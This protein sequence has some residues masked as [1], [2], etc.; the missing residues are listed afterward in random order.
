MIACKKDPL[1]KPQISIESINTLIP[2]GGGLQAK[3]KFT[4][5]N[6]KLATGIFIAIRNRLNQIPLP[7]GTAS[8][9]TLT[10]PIP[11]FPDKNKGEF[12]FTLDYSYLHQSD[13]ENDTIQFKFAVVDAGGNKSDTVTSDKVVVLF[14]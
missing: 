4:Q 13:V 12:L 14:Q 3:L 11:D 1:T 9:D 6:G 8:A 2:V 7:I 5:K 10:G